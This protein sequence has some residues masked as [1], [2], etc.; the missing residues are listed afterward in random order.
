MDPGLLHR[1]GVAVDPKGVKGLQKL[2][3]IAPRQDFDLSLN[4]VGGDDL[5]GL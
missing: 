3:S 4:A 1:I 2:R 5:P